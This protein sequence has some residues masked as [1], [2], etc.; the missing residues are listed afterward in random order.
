MSYDPLLVERIRDM[1]ADADGLTEKKMF[2][3]FGW[4]IHGNM[5]VG[6]HSEGR[7]MLRSSDADHAAFLEEPGA[8][9]IVRGGR[10][11]A[12]WIFVDASEIASDAGLA[13][14]VSRGRAF[15]ESLPPK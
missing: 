6:A 5:A 11:M 14:W 4:M 2:G 1:L 13:R 10:P 15:A 3:G 7:L 8:N 12:R 9:P